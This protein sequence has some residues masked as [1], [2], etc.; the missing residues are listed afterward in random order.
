MLD[1]QTMIHALENQAPW[2]EPG[3]AFGYHV[4]T[5]G[6]LVGEIVRRATGMTIGQFI[7]R[8][9]AGPLDAD[10]YIGLPATEHHRVAEFRWPSGAV[11]ADIPPGDDMAL[12]RWNTYWNPPGISGAHWINTP[13]WRLAEVPSTNG[14]G[15]A[16]A[17]ARV[18]SA[19]ARRRRDRR[20]AH[21]RA[22]K[23]C[24]TR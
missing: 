11:T 24:A 4:N 6:F 18:Y 19:L 12:M 3:T 7:K 22:K 23:L 2:W 8:T 13:A 20:R 15:N 17:I 1:W 16:R 9:I 5:F 21:H 10:L 14:H